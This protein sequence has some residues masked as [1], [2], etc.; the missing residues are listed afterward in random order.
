MSRGNT[1]PRKTAWPPLEAAINLRGHKRA[2]RAHE[3]GGQITRVIPSYARSLN[4]LREG[5]GHGYAPLPPWNFAPFDTQDRAQLIERW[6][7][8]PNPSPAPLLTRVF[9][10]VYPSGTAGK[11]I[12]FR[13]ALD[14]EPDPAP[15]P[16]F[17]QLNSY[18][19][20]VVINGALIWQRP[21]GDMLLIIAGGARMNNAQGLVPQTYKFTAA[22]PTHSWAEAGVI[23][24]PVSPAPTWGLICMWDRYLYQT[25]GPGLDPAYGAPVGGGY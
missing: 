2:Y 7:P 17:A 20:Y 5:P 1:P 25:R 4:K 24:P 21:I 9:R 14:F 12:G 8:A 13:F 15:I 23:S 19:W 10:D 18:A 6:N 11:S 16:S 22:M 3:A